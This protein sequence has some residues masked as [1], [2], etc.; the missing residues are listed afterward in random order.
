MPIDVI[1]PKCQSKLRAP[2]EVVGRSVR[3]KK[4]QEKFKVPNPGA[5]VD[6][7]GDTQMLSLVEVP[8][9]APASASVVVEAIAL[10]DSAFDEPLPVVVKAAVGPLPSEVDEDRPK[11]KRLP[12]DDDEEEEDD[13]PKKKKKPKE[14]PLIGGE[15]TFAMPGASEDAAPV[16][17]PPPPHASQFTFGSPA[18]IEEVDDED[19]RPKSKKK[20]PRADDE[21]DD[22]DPPKKKG[23]SKPAKSKKMLYILGGLALAL[24]VGCGGA[25]AGVYFFAVK[26]A[27]DAIS[28]ATVTVG[29]I[30]T[31]KDETEKTVPTRPTKSGGGTEPTKPPPVPPEPVG[32]VVTPFTVPADRPGNGTVVAPGT[33]TPLL[34]SPDSVRQIH[35]FDHPLHGPMLLAIYQSQAGFNGRG[36]EDTIVRFDLDRKTALE[37]AAPADRIAGLRIFDISDSGDRIAIEA[38]QGRLTVYDFRTK[39]KVFDGLDLYA[40]L[41]EREGPIAFAFGDP[42]GNFVAAVD[43]FG[44]VDVWDIKD[45]QRVVTGTPEPGKSPV[46]MGARKRR[47]EHGLMAGKGWL[48]SVLWKTGQFSPKIN[49]PTLTGVPTVVAGQE[50]EGS[51]IHTALVQTPEGG[52][53]REVLIVDKV[54]TEN[55]GATAAAVWRI[56]L[57]AA[58]GV[59][60]TLRWIE[61]DKILAL[62]FEAGD[63]LL[64]LDFQEKTPLV[65][66]K[67]GQEKTKLSATGVHAL[68]PNPKVPGK[69]AV[70]R[71]TI[72]VGPLA[73]ML[74][75]AKVNKVPERLFAKPEG[76]GQ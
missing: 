7:V 36:A 53:D 41:P 73:A 28:K 1:C 31:K 8:K 69:A 68:M 21:N 40:G 56:P 48:K 50:Q 45:K 13:R 67:A 2:D 65:Y 17:V 32:P 22:D 39:S 74:D 33:L 24:F 60:K 59:P 19:D 44:A 34:F 10:D 61:S 18:P 6:S 14:K 72:P 35:G 23:P 4:C 66:L 52:A 27:T 25:A 16:H 55:D 20:K 38:P 29:T 3:C 57:P 49:V 15:P 62:G 5:P 43:K 26:P 47:G 30:P 9:P 58:A 70:V 51:V 12:D 75:A 71:A 11:K 54:A 37:F 46:A 63:S 64:L 42:D 76:L